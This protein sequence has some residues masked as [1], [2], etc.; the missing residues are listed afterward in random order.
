VAV[1]PQGQ[2]GEARLKEYWLTKGLS[3]WAEKPHPWT[4][5]MRQLRAKMIES[6]TD[7]AR[8]EI[9]A[10]GMATELYHDHFGDFPGSDTAHLRSGRP[11]RGKVVGHG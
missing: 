2:A 9:M 11:I 4:S 10:K 7:P 8:A 5:L 1:T 6:G 3:K